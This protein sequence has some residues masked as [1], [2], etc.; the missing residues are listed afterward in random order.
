M[1]LIVII[2]SGA[3]GKMTVGQELM[4]ITDFRLFHNHMMIEPVIQIFGKFDGQVV[5]KL[6]EDIFDAFSWGAD[7]ICSEAA[8]ELARQVGIGIED[9]LYDQDR[10]V[11]SWAD[12]MSTL[13][14]RLKLQYSYLFA[15]EIGDDDCCSC[16]GKG[17]TVEDFESWNSGVYPEDEVYN[18]ANIGRV[19]TNWTVAKNDGYCECQRRNSQSSNGSNGNE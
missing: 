15:D 6:R 2:G 11:F 8:L 10:F 19:N 18:R 13:R 16:C 9:N 5:S 12:L 7:L 17:Q 1:D 4:K 3:V 14:L